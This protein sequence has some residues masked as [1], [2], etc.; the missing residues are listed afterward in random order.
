MQ[1]VFPGFRIPTDEGVSGFD[2]PGGRAPAQAGHGPFID[3]SDVLEMV[4]LRG[5]GSLCLY[6]PEADDLTISEVMVLLNQRVVERLELCVSDWFE[7]NRGQ[8]GQF[9]L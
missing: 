3:K 7:I 6:E 5:V 2:L 9:I 4:A 8:I 1:I